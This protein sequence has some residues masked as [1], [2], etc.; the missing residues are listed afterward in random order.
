MT[1]RP[2][3]NRCGACHGP[4]TYL[5][6]LGRTDHHRC[7]DC[8]LDQTIDAPTINFPLDPNRGQEYDRSEA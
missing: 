2:H 5:G 1:Q 7:R 6:R 3:S 8:G 4:L